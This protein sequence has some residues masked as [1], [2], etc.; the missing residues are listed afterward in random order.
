MAMEMSAAYVKSAKANIPLAEEIVHDRFHIM[1]MA[2][3]AM[4]KARKTEHRELKENCGKR[5]TRTEFLWL[6]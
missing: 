4:D 3:E 2:N 1:K 6:T 5:R